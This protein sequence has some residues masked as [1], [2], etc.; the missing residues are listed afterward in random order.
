MS[1][2]RTRSP[3][4]AQGGYVLLAWAALLAVGAAVGQ[5]IGD[6]TAF[7]TSV[8]DWALERRT[9]MWNSVS[10]VVSFA[11]GTLIVV[12]IC[13]LVVAVGLIRRRRDGLVVF[14]LAMVGEFALFLT[15]TAFIDRPRPEVEQLDTAPPTSSFPS[16]HTMAS[17]VL[18]GSI[19]V[20]AHRQLWAPALRRL[21]VALAVL[22]PLAVAAGRVYRGMH[23]P[24]DVLTSLLLGAL[25]LLALWTITRPAPVP[26]SPI[27]APEAEAENKRPVRSGPVR[28]HAV[29]DGADTT[30]L[31]RTGRGAS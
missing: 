14:V 22:V 17:A 6:R 16:G 12:S 25:W 30:V 10:S 29:D 8:T 11:G 5:V 7:D 28:D 4:A 2:D 13:A 18:W 23:H 1:D 20:L 19:A 24:S 3:R 26:T 31:S 27:A 15:L 9:E 21:A